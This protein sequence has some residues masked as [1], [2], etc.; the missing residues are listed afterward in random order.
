MN[1]TL[2]LQDNPAAFWI[3]VSTVL[4]IVGGAGWFFKRSQWF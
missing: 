2:P 1:V 4:G 3:I